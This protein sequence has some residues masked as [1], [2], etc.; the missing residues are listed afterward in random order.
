[1]HPLRLIVHLPKRVGVVLGIPAAVCFLAT[2]PESLDFGHGEV[3]ALSPAQAWSTWEL[4]PLITALTFILVAVYLNGMRR[5]RRGGPISGWRHAAFFAGTASIFLALQSPIDPLADHFFF[6]HQIEHLMI[7]HLGALLVVIAMPTA[8]L[9]RGLPGWLRTHVVKPVM[10][11]RDVTASFDFLLHPAI[12]AALFLGAMIFWNV[13]QVHD[14]TVL[15][16]DVHYF[17]H[18]TMLLFGL[19]YWWMLWDPRPKATRRRPWGARILI[20]CAVTVVTNVF[21]AY[22]TFT[23][24]HFYPVYDQL[25]GAWGFGAMR[26]QALGGLILWVPTSMMEGLVFVALVRRWSQADREK[27]ARLVARQAARTAALQGQVA[28]DQGLLERHGLA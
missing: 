8:V 20:L 28:A 17:M 7:M 22:L 21:S 15:H 27:H 24:R 18:Y 4:T 6:M 13:P 25:H 1:M 26:D 5:R 2:L 23:A 9:L 10:Q 16:E 12:A 14:F 3:D 11:S 19:F